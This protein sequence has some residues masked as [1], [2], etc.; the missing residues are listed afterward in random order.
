MSAPTADSFFAGEEADLT[1]VPR[2]WQDRP[3]IRP[4]PGEEHLALKKPKNPAHK[5]LI[6]YDRSS[7]FGGNIE[8]DRNLVRW[9]K[10]QVA[11]GTALMYE[12]GKLSPGPAGGLERNPALDP[13]LVDDPKEAKAYWDSLAE[14]AENEVGSYDKAALGTAI[15]SATEAIDRGDDISGWPELLRDRADAYYR[16]RR[17]LGIRPTSIETFGVEDTY[18]I[19]GTWDRTGWWAGKHCIFDVK[20][21]GTMDF[22]GIGFAVQ[23]AAYAHMKRY[24]PVT[25]ERVPH[26]I[27]DLETGWIIHVDRNLGGPVELFKVDIAS[28][29]RFAGLVAEIKKARAVGPKLIHEVT[30]DDIT[31]TIYQA[32]DTD[33]L[34]GL[35]AAVAPSVEPHHIEAFKEMAAWLKKGWA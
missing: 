23:L 34:H 32:T 27:M 22:A 25:G 16:F 7:Y 3:L 4:I 6:P 2:D 10:R 31:R 5:G 20:T 12:R 24:D 35:W 17:D 28:G 19:A 26:E 29:W 13:A 33:Q 15:H 30:P 21:S 8:D 9:Q 1:G 11:R 14:S 18:H